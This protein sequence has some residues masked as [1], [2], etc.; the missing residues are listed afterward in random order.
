MQWERSGFRLT[1]EPGYIDAER[2]F[3]LLSATYWGVRRPREVVAGMLE[4]SLCFGLFRDDVQVGFARAVTDYT[5]FSWI[6]D[7]VIDPPCR[8]LG[9]G[10]WMMECMIAHPLLERTQMVLQTR[11]AHALYEQYGFRQ[12]PALMSTPVIGL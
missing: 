11:D 9:L 10:R 5:V 6:A 8:G 1:D 4:H 7:L 2:T 3:A 12:N